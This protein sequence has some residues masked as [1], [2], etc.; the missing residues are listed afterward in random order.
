MDMYFTGISP[1][2]LPERAVGEGKDETGFSIFPGLKIR[3][4]DNVTL[5]NSDMFI[6]SLTEDKDYGTR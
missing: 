2:P 4:I 5:L 6:H 3:A 1:L